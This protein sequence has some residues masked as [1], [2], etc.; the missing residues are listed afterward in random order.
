MVAWQEDDLISFCEGFSVFQ[1]SAQAAQAVGAAIDQV[2]EENQHAAFTRCRHTAKPLQQ[3]AQ[4][5]RLAVRVANGHQHSIIWKGKL[6][7]ARTL[8]G[9]TI[10]V[11]D[12]G[13]SFFLSR[14]RLVGGLTYETA[15]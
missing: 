14:L 4:C 8:D 1:S 15:G 11:C 5:A 7:Q 12:H 13:I 9:E 2:T 10:C 3:P 6:L